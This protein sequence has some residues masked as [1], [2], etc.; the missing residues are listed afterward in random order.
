MLHPEGPVPLPVSTFA[1]FDS[2]GFFLSRSGEGRGGPGEQLSYT[3]MEA[4]WHQ[5]TEYR[6][7]CSLPVL[8]VFFRTQEHMLAQSPTLCSGKQPDRES[9][10]MSKPTPLSALPDRLAWSSS[11]PVSWKQSYPG[12]QPDPPT[13]PP[14]VLEPGLQFSELCD[15][16]LCRGT[17]HSSPFSPPALIKCQNKGGAFSPVSGTLPFFGHTD[18]WACGVSG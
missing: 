9:Q 15:P 4:G 12:E 8:I 11:V 3:L 5:S 14:C 2:L 1:A 7:K 17:I 13:S 18:L 16:S 6:W 10:S